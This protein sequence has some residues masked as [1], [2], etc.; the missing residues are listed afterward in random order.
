MLRLIIVMATERKEIG[1]RKGKMPRT[2]VDFQSE[3]EFLPD[4]LLQVYGKVFNIRATFSDYCCCYYLNNVIN[5][6]VYHE[7]EVPFTPQ[8]IFHRGPDN[9]DDFRSIIPYRTR[10]RTL[11]LNNHLGKK[12]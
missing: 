4:D 9:P 1:S 8:E 7:L 3:R 12:R 5:C 6:I 2:G 10:P 11:K